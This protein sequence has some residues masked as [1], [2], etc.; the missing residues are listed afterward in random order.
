MEDL[1]L[2]MEK[3]FPMLSALCHL[4]KKSAQVDLAYLLV[5]YSFHLAIQSQDFPLKYTAPPT[6][7]ANFLPCN[8]RIYKLCPML[9]YRHRWCAFLVHPLQ[10]E[11][12]NAYQ[13]FHC[14]WWAFVCENSRRSVVIGREITLCG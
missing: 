4:I 5:T 6:Q 10:I 13:L 3:N 9:S 7:C 11:T 8:E 1:F 14:R 2:T 12:T